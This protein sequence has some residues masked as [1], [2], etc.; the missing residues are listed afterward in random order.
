MQLFPLFS[1]HASAVE[2]ESKAENRSTETDLKKKV[3]LQAVEE[4]KGAVGNYLMNSLYCSLSQHI[5]RV[6]EFLFCL[7]FSPV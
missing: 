3:G 2:G 4:L 6:V 5:F 1:I 7:P